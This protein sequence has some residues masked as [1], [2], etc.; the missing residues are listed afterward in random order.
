[1]SG[2]LLKDKRQDAI[3]AGK[4]VEAEGAKA[5]AAR[6][7]ARLVAKFEGRLSAMATACAAE[8]KLQQRDVLHLLRGEFRKMRAEVAGNL[9]IGAAALSPM[10]EIDIDEADSSAE[11]AAD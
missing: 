2:S 11:K 9:A 7:A 6:E 5:A 1:L 3:D 8:F 10:V 4:L